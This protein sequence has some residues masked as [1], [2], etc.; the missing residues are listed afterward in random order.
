MH[1]VFMVDLGIAQGFAS[2]LNASPRLHGDHPMEG[3]LASPHPVDSPDWVI[4]GRDAD[5]TP[6]PFT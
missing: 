5:N 4:C 2:G 1:R 6:T 3:V